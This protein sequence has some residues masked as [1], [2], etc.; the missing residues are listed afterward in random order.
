MFT[1]LLILILSSALAETDTQA[2]NKESSSVHK[3]TNSSDIIID[4]KKVKYNVE[5]NRVTIEL[6]EQSGELFYTSYTRNAPV[7]GSNN[8][9]PIA[10]V[11]NGAASEI[12]R[13]RLILFQR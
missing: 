13:L 2:P 8:E 4:S 11:F 12:V 6:G 3:T 1:T 7:F 10:F 5:T 9:R